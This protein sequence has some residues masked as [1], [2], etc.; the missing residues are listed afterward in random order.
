[1]TDRFALET[2]QKNVSQRTEVERLIKDLETQIKP[3]RDLVKN[4]KVEKKSID[5]D[6]CNF[7]GSNG[8]E[9]VNLPHVIKNGV[10]LNQKDGKPAQALKYSVTEAVEPMTQERS[11]KQLLMFFAGPGSQHSFNKLSV[12]EKANKAHDFIYNKDHR[13]KVKKVSLRKVK[14]V[15]QVSVE[16]KVDI[17]V[18]ID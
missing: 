10:A 6:I 16:K 18:A 9:H 14:F 2:F 11:R 13:P 7:M 12:E 4:L 3:L 5:V 15:G 8:A 17:E 1:M